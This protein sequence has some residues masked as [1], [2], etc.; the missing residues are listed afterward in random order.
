MP[1]AIESVSMPLDNVVRIV[2]TAGL[3]DE[4]ETFEP[5]H[6]TFSPRLPRTQPVFADSVVFEAGDPTVVL[7][8]LKQFPTKGGLYWTQVVGVSDATGTKIVAALQAPFA[9][10]SGLSQRTQ[11][12]F[13]SLFDWANLQ[14][15][16]TW[17]AILAGI[18][19]ADHELAGPDPATDGLTAARESIWVDRAADADL[20]V[21]GQNFG[22]ERPPGMDDGTYRAG[23]KAL[24]FQ[25]KLVLALLEELLALLLGD[26]ATIKWEVYEIRPHVITV[27]LGLY[28]VEQ[29]PSSEHYLCAAAND[30]YD[31]APQGFLS[32]D[33]LE[34]NPR[35]LVLGTPM[36]QFPFFRLFL[37]LYRAAGITIEFK[38]PE[39]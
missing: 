10:I 31:D 20:D 15:T 32:S 22:I 24:A 36:S 35:P 11:G 2:F 30:N 9:A 17:A 34:D 19:E 3:K 28:V 8:T 38:K 6:Y 14:S 5:S 12:M 26:K 7:V 27:D 37:D 29:D 4:P 33:D 18:G 16:S 25:P 13:R 1:V 39:E 21:I 23:I